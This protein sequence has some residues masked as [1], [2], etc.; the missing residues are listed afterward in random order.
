MRAPA[1]AAAAAVRREA[2][3]ATRRA[4]RRYASH[5]PVLE[6]WAG[7]TLH[8]QREPL[9]FT[10]GPLTTSAAV[11]HAMLVDIGSRDAR[12]VAV[13]RE[14]R[15][16]LLDMAGV[17]QAA[18]WECALVQGSGTMCVESVVNSAVPPPAEGGRLLV[19]SNGAYGLR[20]AKM[21][22]M[23]GIDVEIIQ[24]GE[25]ERVSPSDIGDALRK[26]AAEGRRFTHV[27]VIHHETTAGTLNPIEEIGAAIR[28]A[29]PQ[30][31]FFVDSMSGFGAYALDLEKANVSYI[32]SSAN[33]NIEG[34]PGF[35]FALARK[36]ELVKATHARSLS[37]DLLAQ[38]KGLENNGQ[39]RFTPPCHSLLAFRQALAEHAAEGGVAGRRARYEANFQ[40]LKRGMAEMGFHPYLS[41]DAQGC[42]ITTFL[43]PDDP[44]FDFPRFYRELSDRGLVIYPGKL[45]KADCFRLGTIGRLFPSDYQGLLCAIREVL[46]GMGVKLPVTQ[47]KTESEGILTG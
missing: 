12:M 2:A 45:T 19:G 47:K 3:G 18:G 14:I 24:Y 26:G 42:I 7:R 30:A 33:K 27:G 10:P 5:Q 4:G 8:Q 1:A 21:A 15:E 43:Y 22:Q 17:S 32:V 11:K 20:M 29:D 9:L 16:L 35:A 46:Q 28:E 25:T 38:W 41:E 40:T 23:Y 44:N 39:F 6:G 36:S 34:I 37:L 13:I 31:A